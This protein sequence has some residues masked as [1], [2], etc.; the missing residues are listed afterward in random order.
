MRDEVVEREAA[1]IDERHD[2]EADHRL[3]DRRD[4]LA[5]R[6]RHRR[7]G[8]DIGEACGAGE[9]D[10]VAADD[11]DVEA[12]NALLL[13]DALE[14]VAEASLRICVPGEGHV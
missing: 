7:A 9:H 1:F 13:D 10:V 2:A 12:G 11:G 5:V 8:F 14:G 6:R 3:G 4:A